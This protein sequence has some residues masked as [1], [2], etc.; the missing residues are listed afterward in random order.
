ML[1]NFLSQWI[2]LCENIF[3]RSVEEPPVLIDG[4]I[5]WKATYISILITIA[6]SP[7]AVNDLKKNRE[8]AIRLT[9]LVPNVKN[10]SR[11][12]MHIAFFLKF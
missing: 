4:E 5:K 7:F 2:L 3:S 9:Y 12:I 11:T 6:V 1:V 10:K 8:D